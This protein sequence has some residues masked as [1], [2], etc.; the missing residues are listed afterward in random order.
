MHSPLFMMFKMKK[1]LPRLLAAVFL[2]LSPRTLQAQ[3]SA[4]GIEPA[5]VDAIAEGLYSYRW[6]LYRSIFL[7][8]KNGVVVTDPISTDATKR[9]RSEIAK[10]TDQPVKY[11]IYSHDHWDHIMGGQ[12]F[13]DEGAEFIA[14]ENCL[15]NMTA[16]PHPDIVLPDTTFSEKYALRL[17][18]KGLDL[19]YF[20]PS[21]GDCNIV[22]I[23]RPANVLFN[24]DLLNPP[25]GRYMP[26]QP[27]LV[28][29]RWAT[30]IDVYKEIE[31]LMAEEGIDS[32]LGGH[33]VMA[34]NGDG[35]FRELPL[36]GPASAMTERRELWEQAMKAV[37][38][39]IDK[40]TP[41]YLAAQRVD[42]TPFEDLRGYD[43]IKM[44]LLLDRIAAYY[45]V[46]H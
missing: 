5:S 27:M 23:P 39:E 34:P 24:V 1:V 16:N 17:G 33:L 25:S 13:K 45:A 12:I 22:M 15:T 41:A 32:V 36:T 20:G 8:T 26:F 28:D 37:K 21:D 14:Q 18:E 19:F 11:V 3:F 4:P 2:G 40:G 43:E 9:M 30:G 38:D 7:I 35:T 6:G 44:R 42:V 29:Y 31:S 46:G 10:L